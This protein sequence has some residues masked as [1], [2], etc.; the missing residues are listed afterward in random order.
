VYSDNVSGCQWCEDYERDDLV[1][2][3]KLVRDQT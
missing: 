2:I 1:I 3:Y